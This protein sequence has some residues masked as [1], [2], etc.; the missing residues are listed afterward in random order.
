MQSFKQSVRRHRR[1]LLRPN[2]TFSVVWKVI[3]VSCV[4]L[5]IAQ[6]ACAPKV[7][8]EMKKM[9]LEELMKG[10]LLLL[11][12]KCDEDVVK[13]KTRKSPPF[14]PHLI[15]ALPINQVGK[16]PSD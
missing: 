5:E 12:E 15:N 16:M 1:I 13:K 9:P 4:A 10:L 14:M 8:G 11:A 2:T 7:A 3:T 6:I